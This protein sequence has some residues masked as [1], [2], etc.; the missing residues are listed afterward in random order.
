MTINYKMVY[1]NPKKGDKIMNTDT[2]ELDV[3]TEPAAPAK[4]PKPRTRAKKATAKK[5]KAAPSS[6]KAAKPAAERKPRSDADRSASVA[7]SWN[8][9]KVAKARAQR[10]K[11]K[12]GGE[13]YNSV[14]AAMTALK[15]PTGRCIPFRAKLKESGKEV[16]EHEGKKFTFTLVEK[17]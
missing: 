15:L 16:F 4:N 11:V 3:T 10:H 7:K 13:V 2:A 9:P 6:R 5:E 8:D 14:F 1:F 12:V 17:E